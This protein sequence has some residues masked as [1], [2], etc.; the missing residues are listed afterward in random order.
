MAYRT[1]TEFLLA[2]CMLLIV[3]FFS[4][5]TALAAPVEA[6]VLKS[7]S[8][9]QI[10]A[11]CLLAVTAAL[12]T[13]GGLLLKAHMDRIVALEKALQSHDDGRVAL[14]EAMKGFTDEVQKMREHCA[15]VRRMT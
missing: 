14:A 7:G 4:V 1:R 10:L 2:I 13:V 3:M 8:E 9:Q 12:V 6:D 11:V 5:A 15:A